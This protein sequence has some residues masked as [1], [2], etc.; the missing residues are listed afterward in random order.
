[1]VERRN[2]LREVLLGR[3]SWRELVAA[4][5]DI[6][7]VPDGWIFGP[8]TADPIAVSERDLREGI[9][10]QLDG[11]D[12]GRE[13]ASFVLSASQLFDFA[14]L[15]RDGGAAA[16]Q[17]LEALWDISYGNADAARKRL[18]ESHPPNA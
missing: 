17:V 9:T 11:E 6:R 12:R 8:A 10:R 14:S 1:M 7:A 3:A 2:V 15:S 16:D 18:A 13:W 4:G 5:A